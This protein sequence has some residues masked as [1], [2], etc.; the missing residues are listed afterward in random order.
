MSS[1][2]CAHPDYAACDNAMRGRV[3]QYEILT[4]PPE[5][6]SAYVGEPLGDGAPLDKFG[7]R[8]RRSLTVWTGDQIG[9]IFLGKGWRSTSYIGSRMYQAHATIAGRRY[10]GR[11][12]GEG[13][14]VNLR[15]TAASRRARNV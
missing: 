4:N 5:R 13:M 15:E 6:L 9:A 12:F 11:T 10:T 3:E 2:L 7:D 1:E 14:L 8:S